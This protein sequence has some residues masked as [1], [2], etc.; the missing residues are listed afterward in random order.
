M[1]NNPRPVYRDSHKVDQPDSTTGIL[2][3][4]WR[5]C[6]SG[7]WKRAGGRPAGLPYSPHGSTTGGN[8]P[9]GTTF[10]AALVRQPFESDSPPGGRSVLG[11]RPEGTSAISLTTLY[12]DG[13]SPMA[14]PINAPRKRF[15][16]SMPG[17]GATRSRAQPGSTGARIGA[18]RRP[19]RTDCSR[20][21]AGAGSVNSPL[22]SVMT[23]RALP[24]LRRT[25]QKATKAT[26]APLTGSE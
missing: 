16:R 19:A 26:T 24:C 17:A 3:L 23:S 6:Q 9:A 4:P 7:T 18:S 2:P 1:T 5:P 20:P 22:A 12:R 15:R 8:M 13:A 21:L 25:R 10:L 14:P 11:V